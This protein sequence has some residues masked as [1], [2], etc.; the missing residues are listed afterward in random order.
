MQIAAV[1]KSGEN[2][3]GIPGLATEKRKRERKGKMEA[4]GWAGRLNW[5]RA[6]LNA[7]TDGVSAS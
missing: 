2:R 1:S 4:G 7:K 5:A 6:E 3:R